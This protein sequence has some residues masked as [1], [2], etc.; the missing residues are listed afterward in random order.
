MWRSGGLLR[1][2]FGWRDRIGFQS[3]G[4]LSNRAW[5]IGR[6]GLAVV[7]AH[8]PEKCCNADYGGSRN[9]HHR[10]AALPVGFKAI[11]RATPAVQHRSSFPVCFH[12]NSIAGDGVP[13]RK[14]RAQ[15]INIGAVQAKQ[16]LRIMEVDEGNGAEH[17]G[18]A[19][20]LTL[21]GSNVLTEVAAGGSVTVSLEGSHAR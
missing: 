8:C 19:K 15:K 12:A 20:T 18:T 17:D 5:S 1:A 16:R 14:L 3:R 11:R 10:R 4:G 21:L 6:C 9:R 13:T 2:L 7:P